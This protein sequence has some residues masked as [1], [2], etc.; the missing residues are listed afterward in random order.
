[1]HCSSFSKPG[2]LRFAFL[3][4]ALMAL[5][6]VGCGDSGGG[7]GG[8]DRFPPIREA[9]PIPRSTP[10]ELGIEPWVGQSVVAAPV[11]PLELTPHPFLNN[12]GDSRIHN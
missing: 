4:S 12:T 1:M 2:A 6:V 3:F 9:T 7:A 10:E 11:P 8:A 5:L